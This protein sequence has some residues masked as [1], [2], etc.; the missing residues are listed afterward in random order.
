MQTQETRKL[1]SKSS[2]HSFLEIARVPTPMWGLIKEQDKTFLFFMLLLSLLTEIKLSETLMKQMRKRQSL[3]DSESTSR[4]L[5]RVDFSMES[6]FSWGSSSNIDHEDFKYILT[7]LIYP[8]S[9]VPNCEHMYI[10]YY[11]IGIMNS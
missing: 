9:L 10:S 4:C 1:M 3:L 2:F 8:Q 11:T 6:P 5:P 7:F